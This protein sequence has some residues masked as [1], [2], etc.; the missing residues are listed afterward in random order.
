MDAVF[1][2]RSKKA[3]YFDLHQTL[4]D[5]QQSFTD[6]FIT[7]LQEYTGRWED[8]DQVSLEK[9]AAHYQSEWRKRTR[10]KKSPAVPPDKIRQTCLSLALAPLP[11]PTNKAFIQ[12]FLQKVNQLNSLHPKLYPGVRD[13]L[14]Y[15]ASSYTLGLISN[16][17]AEKADDCIVRLHLEEYFPP[18]HR[19]TAVRKD[20]KKPNAYMFQQALRSMGIRKQQAVMAGNSWHTDVL[21]AVRC[22]LDAVWFHPSHK[23]KNSPKSVGSQTVY[24]VRSWE[25]L[26]SLFADK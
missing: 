4:L 20:Q 22:G 11:L 8:R 13:A 17:K 26:A 2:P 10:H 12:T 5:T 18:S 6:S 9:V 19:F 25:Q 1:S 24:V 21:G 14:N 15:L 3:I 7:V 16:G 23:E